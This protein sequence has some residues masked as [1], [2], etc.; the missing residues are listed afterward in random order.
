MGWDGKMV[1]WLSFLNDWGVFCSG[2]ASSFKIQDSVTLS[3]MR[4]AASLSEDGDSGKGVTRSMMMVVNA[5]S[6]TCLPITR[7]RRRAREHGGLDGRV[8]GQQRRSYQCRDDN[9]QRELNRH[10]GCKWGF[11][12][13]VADVNHDIWPVM[14]DD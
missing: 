12:L 3:I 7:R 2:H 13:G 11:V 4:S 8:C 6:C 10:W 5:H 9:G 1:C 14:I